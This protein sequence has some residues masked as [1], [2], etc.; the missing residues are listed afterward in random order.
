MEKTRARVKSGRFPQVRTVGGKS[1][2][3]PWAPPHRDGAGRD[4]IAA[5]C[6]GVRQVRGL[7]R[8]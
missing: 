7:A 6:M 4:G 1:V 8:G 2:L 3:I 5:A